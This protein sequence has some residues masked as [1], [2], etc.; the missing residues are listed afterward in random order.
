MTAEVTYKF[1]DITGTDFV[2][3]C[4]RKSEDGSWETA[5]SANLKQYLKSPSPSM[6][7]KY[8]Q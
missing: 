8:V 1:E 3:E 6:T 2:W 5:T 7:L 4:I